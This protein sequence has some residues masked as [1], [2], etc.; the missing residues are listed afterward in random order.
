LGDNSKVSVDDDT[1]LGLT[2]EYMLNSNWGVE[3]LAATPFSHTASAKGGTLS[4]LT[5]DVAD[6]KQLPPTVSAVYH[7]NNGEELQPYVGVGINYTVFFSEDLSS[8]TVAV[9][10]D[11]NVELDDSWGLALQIGVDYHLNERWLVNASVRWIDID[12]EATIKLDSG[13]RV[14]V[15]VDIDPMVY[16]VMV[17]YKF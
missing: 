10:G 1:Q 9:L 6:V 11:G 8:D 4:T 17:G 14:D 16:S 5:D 15:D 3:V 12:T 13:S 7:F 2:V